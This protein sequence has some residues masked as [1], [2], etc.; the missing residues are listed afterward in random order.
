MP[1]LGGSPKSGYE[2]KTFRLNASSGLTGKGFLR[3]TVEEG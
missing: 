3:T 2:F 1:H